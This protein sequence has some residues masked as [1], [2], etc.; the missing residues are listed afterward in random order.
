MPDTIVT[1]IRT[2]ADVELGLLE[3]DPAVTAENDP[4]LVPL[5]QYYKHFDLSD[6]QL[7][8][9][10]RYNCWGFTFLPRR[11]WINSQQDVD[12]IL[13]DNCVPVAPGSVRPGD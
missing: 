8:R 10:K 1:G 12:Q 7:G 4:S 9:T 5:V 3:R 13:S 2:A 11:Y 6:E